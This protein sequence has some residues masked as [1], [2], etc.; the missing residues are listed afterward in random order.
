VAAL[1]HYLTAHRGGTRYQFATLSAA[2]ASTLIAADAQP[3]LVLAAS[4][5]RPLV[6][7]GRLARAVAVGELRYVLVS[8]KAT[9]CSRPETATAPWKARMLAWVQT[10]GTDVT[11]QAGLRGCGVLVRVTGHVG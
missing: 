4:P 6:S 9:S 2:D 8:R 1:S 5:Y 3:V 7:V 11:R 10:H